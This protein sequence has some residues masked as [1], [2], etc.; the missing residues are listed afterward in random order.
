MRAT[1]RK[2]FIMQE[3]QEKDSVAV[4]PLS[5]RLDTSKVTIRKDLDELAEK[6]LVVRTH[7]GAVLAEKQ[8]LSKYYCQIPEYPIHAIH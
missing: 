8:N 3:L 4:I 1:Q 2:N 7:G 6:G 5:L